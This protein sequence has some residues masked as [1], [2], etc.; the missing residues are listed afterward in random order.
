M[1]WSVSERIGKQFMLMITSIVLARLL[2]P[3]DFGLMGMLSIFTSVGQSLIDSGFGSALIQKKD[4]DDVDASSIF[5]FN[6][7]VSFLLTTLLFL[8][9]SRIADFFDQPILAPMTRILSFN[10]LIISFGVVQTAL[11]TKNMD[12]KVQLKVS[13]ISVLISGIIAII[14]AYF[15]FGVWSLVAQFITRFAINSLLLWMFSSW[16][17]SLKFSVSSLKNMFAYGSNL[18]IS[19]LLTTIFDNI[20]DAFI[21]KTYSARDLGFYTKARTLEDSAT[22]STGA[23]LSK[24]AFSAF[25]PFQDENASLK[26][27]YRRTI[28]MSMFIHFPLMIGLITLADP[29]IRFLLTDKWAPTIPYFQLFCV[30][31]LLHPLQILNLNILK[32]K[33]KTNVYLRLNIIKKTLI[34]ISILLTFR[35]GI[36][37]LLVGRIIVDIISY[38]INSFYSERLIGYSQID[39]IKD[40]SKSF[41]LAFIMGISIIIFDSINMQNLLIRLIINSLLGVLVYAFL[42]Y[43]IKSPELNEFQNILASFLL[44]AKRKLKDLF[45]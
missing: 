2:N 43:L 41:V 22:K 12:F 16:R 14:M 10:F 28:K 3:S 35:K 8:S 25:S 30:I 20:Y 5:Y 27:A 36:I 1:F 34:L 42:N 19:G 24:V 40:I 9:A 37:G 15:G 17:P 11:F 45:N 26:K 7:V 44:Q 29:L 33:S 18:L 31:G 32:V 38:F 21:G 39:Q 6:L 13:S 23:S 4:A